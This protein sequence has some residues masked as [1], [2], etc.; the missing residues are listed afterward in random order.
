MSPTAVLSLAMQSLISACHWSVVQ[1]PFGAFVGSAT[2]PGA[3]DAGIGPTT[4]V[5]A[6]TSTVRSRAVAR[7][8]TSHLR[9]GCADG[10]VGLGR[11]GACRCG[12]QVLEQPLHVRHVD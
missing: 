5:A 10:Q 4:A 9:V 2:G 8:T 11:G 7:R 1:S 3:A 12:V 6:A